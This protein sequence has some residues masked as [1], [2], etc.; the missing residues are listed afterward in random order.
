MDRWNETEYK[1]RLFSSALQQASQLSPLLSW[2]SQ[3]PQ[4]S[5]RS[6]AQQTRALNTI[7]HLIKNKKAFAGIGEKK[8]STD[9]KEN[10]NSTPLCAFNL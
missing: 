5:R 8:L 3:H 10:G 2:L 4:L 9:T 1:C 6:L 7:E